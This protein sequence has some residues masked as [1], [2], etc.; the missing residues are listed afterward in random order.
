M[1]IRFYT[2]VGADRTP[3]ER[4]FRLA[5]AMKDGAKAF[6]DT[7]EILHNADFAGPA[8][9][10]DVA[11]CW[12]IVGN[13]RAIVD[14]YTATGKRVLQFD[15]ALIRRLGGERGYLRV[16]LDGPSPV[17]YLMRAPRAFDRWEAHRIEL[18]PRQPREGRPVIAFAGSSQKNCTFFGLGDANDYAEMVLGRCRD[19]FKKAELVYRPKP[20]WSGFRALPMARLSRPPEELAELLQAANVLITHNSSAAIEA[21]VLGVPA[22]TLGPCAAQFVSAKSV[23]DIRDPYFP[24]DHARFQWA[25]NLAYCQWTTEEMASGE[26][27]AFLRTEIQHTS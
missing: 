20:T 24:S 14:A 2:S 19:I 3:K 6:G 5:E 8:P 17:K 25:C 7:V 9:E 11:C 12:G 22:I 23:D 4:V 16:G 15:K 10:V 26:A 13:A 27:W 18:K 1:L 21:V